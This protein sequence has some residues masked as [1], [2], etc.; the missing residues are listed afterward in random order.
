[1]VGCVALGMKSIDEACV[2]DTM[3]CPSA[4]V[5]TLPGFKRPQPMVFAGLFPLDE[6]G[7]DALRHA[8]DKFLLKVSA[9]TRSPSPSPSLS[10]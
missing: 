4:P 7:Y 1:M 5:E 10:R 2:G 6:G 8:M 3:F 9:P